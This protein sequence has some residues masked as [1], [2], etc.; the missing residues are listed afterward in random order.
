MYSPVQGPLLIKK[1]DG[2]KIAEKVRWT[3]SSETSEDRCGIHWIPK[4][5]VLAETRILLGIFS[6]F[7][8]TKPVLGSRAV[9]SLSIFFF[10]VLPF[11]CWSL[12]GLKFFR[13]LKF[14]KSKDTTPQFWATDCHHIVSLQ[15]NRFS[16]CQRG[17]ILCSIK[18]KISKSDVFKYVK[19]RNS[20]NPE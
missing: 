5:E 9:G 7:V 10:L 15:A 3:F 16:G 11:V 8:H 17:F 13:S 19:K 6:L 4:L 14:Y 18:R 1:W 12:V 2:G 20:D